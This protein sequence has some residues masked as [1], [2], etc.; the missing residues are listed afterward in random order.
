MQTEGTAIRV[1]GAAEVCRAESMATA[2]SVSFAG[3]CYADEVERASGTCAEA[4]QRQAVSV[5]FRI[6]AKRK[7]CLG[8]DDAYLYGFRGE[9]ERV[10]WLSAFEFARWVEVTMAAMP[11]SSSVFCEG[12]AFLLPTASG[13]AASA[14]IRRR[15][16]RY[17]V[18]I[19][20][21]GVAK[22]RSGAYKTVGLVPGDDYRIKPGGPG[23]IPFPDH[24]KTQGWRH[25]WVMVFRKRPVVPTF[26]GA[27]LPKSHAGGEERA[28]MLLMARRVP[29]SPEMLA[30]SMHMASGGF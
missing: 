16:E 27:P 20:E 30:S 7:V 26:A 25:D 10:R 21:A 17:H 13:E 14:S 22:Y 2:E 9:D 24:P 29:S 4:A 5:D 18:D 28:A 19:T 11:K 1:N 3:K 15:L 12:S 23:W 6:P 8:K